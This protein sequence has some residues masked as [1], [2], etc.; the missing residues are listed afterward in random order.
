MNKFPNQ[1]WNN[2]KADYPSSL[3]LHKLFEQQVLKSP[4]AVAFIERE[5]QLTYTMLN[6]RANQLAYTLKDH[7]IKTGSIVACHLKT[8]SEVLLYILAILKAGATYLLLDPALPSKRLVYMIQNADATF[9]VTDTSFTFENALEK[10]P[11]V[12]TVKELAEK[13]FVQKSEN[14]DIAIDNENAAYIAYTSGTTGKP[15]AVLISHRSSVNHAYAFS[16]KFQLGPDDCIPLIASIT[17]DV[18]IEEMVPPLI[19]GCKMVSLNPSYGSIH[20]F[21]EEVSRNKCTLLNLPA[22]L[23]HSWSHYLF[24]NNLPIPE[25]LRI[26]I[27]GS[28]KIYTKHYHEWCQLNK[29]EKVLWVGAYGTTETAVTSSFYTPT[30]SDDLTKELLMPIGKPIANTYLYLLDENL[31]PLKSGEVGE[32]YIGGHG[33]GEGYH[34]MPEVTAEKFL[35]DPFCEEP[36]GKMYATGDLARYREDGNFVCLGRKDLQ[37]K[38]NGLRFELGEIEAIINQHEDVKH[39]YVIMHQHDE[40]EQSKKFIV[41]I[42]IKE[43]SQAKPEDLKAH[44]HNWSKDKLP[45]YVQPHSFIII[46]ELPLTQNG[47]VDRSH[48][49]KI[50]LNCTN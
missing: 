21:N 26:V 8:S 10:Y 49:E 24:A 3:N 6:Q 34:K 32:L 16:K 23:W 7:G 46:N 43:N 50:A 47:K 19:T 44:L 9:V 18:A 29:A 41:F 11:L 36:D 13:S 2:T 17:F 35:P 1:I 4:E 30:S 40:E 15:K 31:K 45:H 48:L 38:I 25:N 5:N 33:I 12:Y 28:D 22:P 42:T 37:I 27:V 14:L 39:S 20:E